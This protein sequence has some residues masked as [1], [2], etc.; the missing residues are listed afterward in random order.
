MD[1][2]VALLCTAD[3]LL[4]DFHDLLVIEGLKDIDN[5]INVIKHIQNEKSNLTNQRIQ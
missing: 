2:L 1:S 4:D 3:E 5:S